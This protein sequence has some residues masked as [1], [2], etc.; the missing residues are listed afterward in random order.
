MTTV[1]A[2]LNSANANPLRCEN[3][4]ANY[5]VQQFEINIKGKSQAKQYLEV[6]FENLSIE[7]Q[8]ESAEVLLLQISQEGTL[9]LSDEQKK[10]ITH[11]RQN[12]SYMRSVFQ[13]SS[14]KH[15]SPKDFANF[16]R[17]FGH[18]KDMILINE[19]EKAKRM[20]SRILAKYDFI[21][22]KKILKNVKPATRKSTTK[23]FKS[24]VKST[25]RILAQPYVTVDELHDVRKN[26]RDILRYLQIQNEV[27]HLIH[28][29]SE[30][31]YQLGQDDSIHDTPEILFLK[32]TNRQLGKICDENAGLIIQGQLFEDTVIEFP[33]KL[34]TRVQ[35]IIQNL[36]IQ[37]N[38]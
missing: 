21:D 19:S 30:K 10:F 28:E 14:L 23:Y 12:S 16:V 34:K 26:L 31:T 17:D 15:R 11:F 33:E 3:L 37:D 38:Q 2:Q 24:I 7:S 22:F 32:K 9:S 20:S 29:K 18:L 13:T 1:S 35:Y 8:T 25:N 4:F 6:A 36:Q 5:K 27:G